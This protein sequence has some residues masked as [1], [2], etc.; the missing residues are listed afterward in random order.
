MIGQ[1][2]EERGIG[3]KAMLDDGLFKKFPTPGHCLALHVS[4]ELPA[5]AVALVEG[6]AMANVDSVDI[7]IRGVGGHGAYP[8]KTKDPVLLAAQTILA[9]QTI[10]SRETE[11]LQPAVVTVGS[12]HGGT[13]HNIVPAEVKLQL[14]VRSF[15]DQV[16]QQTLAA[17]E[18]ITRGQAAAAGVPAN[19]QP[20][21]TVSNE[22][23]PALHNDPALTQRLRS[24]FQKVLG[25]NHVILG[26]PVMGGEDFG[27]YGQTVEAIPICLY[28]LGA[29]APRGVPKGD[30]ES[31]VLPS[32]HS[33]HFA[34][35]ARPTIET[36]VL[37][38]TAA[39]LD[40]LGK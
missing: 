9:L 34:P 14:T 30:K 26:K 27:R 12:V 2:A 24:T 11:P 3:A 22:H 40:L 31:A 33:P 36:G 20:I 16:R 1:P 7:T 28:W 35:V 38:M 21:V 39:V 6:P 5:G 17:I 10:V 37:T 8:H 29:V 4:A 18:R 15:T 13:K 19:L 32:L 25:T 23:T